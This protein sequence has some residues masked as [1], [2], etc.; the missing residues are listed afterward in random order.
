M[1]GDQLAQTGANY[2]V[3]QLVFGDM[4]VE[5]SAKSI[6]LFASEVMPTLMTAHQSRKVAASG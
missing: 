4:T 3:S 2:L 1:L 6:G 5:E